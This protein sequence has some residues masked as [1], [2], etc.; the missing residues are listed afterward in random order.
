M[1]P[2]LQVKMKPNKGYSVEVLAMLDILDK[3]Q[4]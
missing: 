3:V 2:F 4:L 1:L